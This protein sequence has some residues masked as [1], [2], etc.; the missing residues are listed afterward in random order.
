MST[1][2]ADPPKPLTPE[3]LRQGLIK[4]IIQLISQQIFTLAV[5][6]LCAGSFTFMRAYY[7]VGF[8]TLLVAC[9]AIYVYPR[10]PEVIVERSRFHEGTHKFDKIILPIYFMTTLALFITGGIDAGRYH[11]MPIAVNPWAFVGGFLTAFG[12]VFIAGAL[13]ANPHLEMTARIQAERGHRVITTGPYRWVRHPM[14][15][16]TLIQFFGFPLL[17]GSGIALVP[18]VACAIVLII[19]TY[20]EDQMLHHELEGYEAYAKNTKYRLIPWIF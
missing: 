10:N 11:W 5:L 9:N 15:L 6:L 1:P 18:C 19:R 12:T 3:E 8:V 4:R 17:I 2:P 14:Y 16:G 20:F 7:Y 13:G